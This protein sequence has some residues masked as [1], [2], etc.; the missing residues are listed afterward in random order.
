MQEADPVSLPTGVVSEAVA[1]KWISSLQGVNLKNPK[2]QLKTG[3]AYAPPDGDTINGV[4]FFYSN[5]DDRWASVTGYSNI[6][7]KLLDGKIGLPPED[8]V[9]LSEAEDLKMFIHNR[10]TKRDV[11]NRHAR[12]E[13]VGPC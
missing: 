6:K 13:R 1:D 9:P 3:I 12:S 7:Q 2:V 11:R 5:T 10:K 8:K 4:H